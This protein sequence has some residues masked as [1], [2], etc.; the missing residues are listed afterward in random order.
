[1]PVTFFLL[2]HKRK[3]PK[4]KGAPARRHHLAS[5]CG[6]PALLARPGGR[7]TRAPSSLL[8]THQA[9]IACASANTFAARPSSTETP[10]RSARARRRLGAPR[11]KAVPGSYA[12]KR[13][14]HIP[15]SDFR[16]SARAARR[17]TGA[18]KHFYVREDAKCH[19]RLKHVAVDCADRRHF[20]AAALARTCFATR[21]AAA[22]KTSAAVPTSN[23]IVTFIV[24]VCAETG[25]RV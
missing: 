23:H 17:Q 18:P 4:K 12:G 25:A 14:F 10:G 7:V 15:P 11:S 5:S 8:Q 22:N 3:S 1:M 2:A 24:A 21:P 6:D 20:P 9:L 19:W 13:P 16:L